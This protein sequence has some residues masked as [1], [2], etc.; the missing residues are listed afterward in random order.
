M[1]EFKPRIT[2]YYQ[3][4]VDLKPLIEDPLGLTHIHLSSIHFGKGNDNSPYIHL[5][6][7]DPRDSKMNIPWTQ[8]AELKEKHN[9]K[10]VLMIGGAGGAYDTLFSDYNTYYPL[11]L[12]LLEE[13]KDIIDG[14]D[15]DIEEGVD[16]AMV[17]KMLIDIKLKYPNYIIS[18]APLAS[19]LSNDEQG[20]GGFS[21]KSIWN[22]STCR[23]A[24]TYFNGQFYGDYTKLTYDSCVKNGYPSQ[25]V[26]MGMLYSPDPNQMESNYEE[27][28]NCVNAY[29]SKF[30]GAYIW[31]YSNDPNWLLRVSE[32][33]NNQSNNNQ[34]NLLKFNNLCKQKISNLNNVCSKMNYCNIL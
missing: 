12:E 4:M 19:S 6:N 32:I 14:I 20:M 11:L 25:K 23:N 27:L 1:S 7:D 17:E 9:I 2:I 21:Y 22:S 15:L 34:S 28:S 10:I 24:I 33:I 29:G 13:K 5:N 26:V 16:I 18:F 3:T 8:L 30:G 31:E